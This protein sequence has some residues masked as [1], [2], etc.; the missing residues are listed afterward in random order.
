M[1]SA[2]SELVIIQVYFL[3]FSVSFSCLFSGHFNLLSRCSLYHQFIAA[4]NPIIPSLI[5]TFLI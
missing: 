1:Y 4:E 5:G 2:H 3:G